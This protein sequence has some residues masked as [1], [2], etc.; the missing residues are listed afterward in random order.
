MAKKYSLI[1][2]LT[3]SALLCNAQEKLTDNIFRKKLANG[4]EILVIED[5]SVPLATVV[6]S[7]K[8]GAFTEP[9]GMNG[10]TSLYLS[11]LGRGNRDYVNQQDLG[12]HAGGLGMQLRN[13]TTSDEYATTYFTL[14]AANLVKG[15]NFMNSAV[16]YPKMDEDELEKTKEICSNQ[17]SET[18]SNPY[19]V[20]G[21]SIRKH[22][23]GSLYSRKNPT[24]DPRVINAATPATLD[25]IKKRY[26]YPNN[27]IMIVG[28]DVAHEVVF[29]EIEQV[30]GDW[31]PAP[32]DP[33]TKWPIPA[34]EPLRKST[35]TIVESKQAHVPYIAIYWQGPDTR[36]DIAST[37]TADVFSYI[38][39]QNS[40]K[41]N[42]ALIQSGLA[43]TVQIG[44][45]TCKYVGPISLFITPNPDKIKECVE[46][47][48]R[49][50]DLMDSDDYFTEEQIETSRRMLEIANIREEEITTTYVH[51]LSYWWT[52]ASINYT[53]GYN[54]NLKKVTKDELKRYVE[55]YIKNR[56]YSAGLLINPDLR[57]QSNADSFFK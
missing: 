52:A 31:A 21:D 16:R 43:S 4:L 34:F 42:K 7:F 57:A 20:L 22:L 46:E 2:L 33:F 54:D 29:K 9:D 48:K 39:N 13:S 49:Q 11:M 41:L 12:Y 1:I 3:V 28:G 25:V 38:I 40:S 32:F 47:V 5:H 8:A 6:L 51:T 45:L 18:E 10:L 27:A 44:Y 56:P 30:Y 35:Y 17:Q 53:L 26:F 19:Y 24:G 14:P 36:N 23:W 37:Y 15:L 55:K 50:I